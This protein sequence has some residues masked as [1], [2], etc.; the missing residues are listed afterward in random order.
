MGYET[1]IALQIVQID[2]VA[3]AIMRERMISKE[4]LRSMSRQ[5]EWGGSWP[6]KRTQK[7]AGKYLVN[8]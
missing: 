6:D 3:L 4:C 7:D 2:M 1:V 8:W 5:G